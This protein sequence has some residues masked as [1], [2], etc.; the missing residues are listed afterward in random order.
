MYCNIPGY[1]YIYQKHVCLMKFNISQKRKFTTYP[2]MKFIN[3]VSVLI[4]SYIIYPYIPCVILIYYDFW[5][6]WKIKS[7]RPLPSIICKNRTLPSSQHWIRGRAGQ[8][9]FGSQQQYILSLKK[10]GLS[11]RDRECDRDKNL[12]DKKKKEID[13]FYLILFSCKENKR[14]R[15]PRRRRRRRMHQRQ[16]RKTKGFFFFFVLNPY[17]M[18]VG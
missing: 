14:R 9:I 1:W 3:Y 15:R 12:E 17:K 7:P 4:V 10:L 5:K 2:K 13:C 11:E 16:S 6:N 18:Y 8:L